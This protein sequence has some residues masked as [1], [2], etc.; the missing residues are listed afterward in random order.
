MY[1]YSAHLFPPHTK[2]ACW[3]ASNVFQDGVFPA[4]YLSKRESAEI[5]QMLMDARTL[6]AFGR[7]N[8]SLVSYTSWYYVSHLCSFVNKLIQFANLRTIYDLYTSKR[9]LQST[10]GCWYTISTLE[11]YTIFGDII[12]ISIQVPIWPLCKNFNKRHFDTRNVHPWPHCLLGRQHPPPAT[13]RTARD[14]TLIGQR[15]F[16]C[17]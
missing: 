12:F 11:F 17:G 6:D 8:H 4:E 13:D 1:F 2:H 9:K 15:V 10:S 3:P 5:Q 7:V 16:W 14:L